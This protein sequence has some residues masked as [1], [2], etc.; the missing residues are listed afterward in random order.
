MSE[1]VA[2]PPGVVSTTD[3]VPEPA[4]AVKV[5]LVAEEQVAAFDAPPTVSVAGPGSKP[6]PVIV[7]LVPPAVVTSAGDSEVI[8]GPVS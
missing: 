6:V 4:G 5:Q 1:L 2:E 3:S 8:V 7:T